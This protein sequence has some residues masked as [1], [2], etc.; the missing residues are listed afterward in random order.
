MASSSPANSPHADDASDIARRSSVDR[1]RDVGKTVA[2][3]FAT[4]RQQLATGFTLDQESVERAASMSAVTEEQE[5]VD[6]SPIRDLRARLVSSEERERT[7]R[8]TIRALRAERDAQTRAAARANA[9]LQ[10]LKSEVPDIGENERMKIEIERLR[11]DVARLRSDGISLQRALE[12]SR[13]KCTDSLREIADLTK[14]KSAIERVCMK[15]RSRVA[16]AEKEARRASQID[17]A[18]AARDRARAELVVVKAECDEQTARAEDAELKRDEALRRASE[19]EKNAEIARNKVISDDDAIVE[20]RRVKRDLKNAMKTIEEQDDRIDILREH[21]R[22]YSS[23][24]T[25]R[26]KTTSTSSSSRRSRTAN[27][28]RNRA[29]SSL[30]ILEDD[31]LFEA[32]VRIRAIDEESN[33][34]EGSILSKSKDND[35]EDD[36]DS[37]RNKRSDAGG[38]SVHRRGG[39]L[40]Q[41]SP[42]LRAVERAH[43]E[44]QAKFQE[45]D[46]FAADVQ[47]RLG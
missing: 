44:L 39:G 41:A 12:R 35:E 27:S 17:D 13:S 38:S 21:I 4:L 11:G 42:L 30:S 29:R 40:P 14:A 36:E 22:N 2:D 46:Q 45:S 28:K 24:S 19:A 34:S 8:G 7:L 18:I 33:G 23:S 25:S 5:N 31:S 3:S 20:L 16:I 26:S 9:K 6:P 43:A 10:S 1:I 47:G 37:R 32:R 15:L